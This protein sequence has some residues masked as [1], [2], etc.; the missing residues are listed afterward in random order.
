MSYSPNTTL[1]Y[2]VSS[3]LCLHVGRLGNMRAHKRDMWSRHANTNGKRH[4]AGRQRRN[5]MS[6]APDTALQ[7]PMS[8]ELCLHVG[9]LGDVRAYKWDVWSWH[10]NSIGKR[11]DAGCQRWYSM[12]AAPDSV[13]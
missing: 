2:S 5:G 1:Q 7:H 9:Q 8:R 6:A 3:Q 13:M 10:A 11:D 12:S 4:D